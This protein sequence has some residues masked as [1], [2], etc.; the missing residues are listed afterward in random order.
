MTSELC[1]LF[2]IY[3]ETCILSKFRFALKSNGLWF[4]CILSDTERHP[5][6][7]DGFKKDMI[8]V[9]SLWRLISKCTCFLLSAYSSYI[10]LKNDASKEFRIS[11][12]KVWG[13]TIHSWT[14][15]SIYKLR[16]IYR[17]GFNYLSKSFSSF[18]VT[19]I[20]L[21]HSLFFSGK[22]LFWIH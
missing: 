4:S 16:V 9:H 21:F 13:N 6:S 8:P 1:R 7:T 11:Y 18:S 22:K 20:F 12:K 15:N 17:I 14:L 3:R 2:F 19:V 10:V 5:Q